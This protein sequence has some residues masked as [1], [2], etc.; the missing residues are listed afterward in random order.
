LTPTRQED[1]RTVRDENARAQPVRALAQ[2]L[3]EIR[4][5]A[6]ASAEQA[7]QLEVNANLGRATRLWSNAVDA[8]LAAG[9]AP[10]RAVPAVLPYLA[11]VD[12]ILGTDP[13]SCPLLDMEDLPQAMVFYYLKS[14]IQ[15]A[16]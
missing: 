5:E 6:N 12:R 9:N 8:Q 11:A 7:K 13:K 14:R 15:K 16:P 3:E 1:G 4:F 2:A 10:P